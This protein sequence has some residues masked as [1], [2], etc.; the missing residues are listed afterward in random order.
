[1]K[2]NIIN[3]IIIFVVAL[4]APQI[5]QAQGTITYLSNLG[6][7]STGSNSVGSD[8]W[9]ATDFGT[10]NNVG[11]HTLNSIQLALTD[12]TGDPDDFTVMLYAAG[13]LISGR[14]IPATSLI[15]LNGPL[16][17]AS[18]GIYTYTPASNF[19]LLF[20]RR[21]CKKH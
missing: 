7:A 8:S 20:A 13:L 15:T 5:A 9:L 3:L 12:A 17:P 16:N 19:I 18:G 14:P 11:G 1:M 21:S 4:L 6:Q 10:G 2:E